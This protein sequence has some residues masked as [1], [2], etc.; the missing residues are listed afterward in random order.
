M[1]KGRKRKIVREFIPIILGSDENAYACARMFYE[2]SKEKSLVFCAKALPQTAHSGILSRFVIEDFDSPLV[3]R[4]VMNNVLSRLQLKAK[5]LLIIPCSDY[6]A[7]LVIR[8]RAL[9]SKYASSPIIRPELYEKI[10]DKISFCELCE[11]YGISH[12]KTE[13]ALPYTILAQ[14]K[15]RQFP[16]VLKPAN[17]N[18][19]EYLHSEFNGKKKVYICTNES[20]L[21]SA[22]KGFIKTGYNKPVV[23]QEYIR[24]GESL[25]RVVNAY[26]DTQGRV[27]L[28]GA[29]IPLLEYKNDREIGN[30]AAIRTVFD[31]KLC[32]EA[33]DILE[34]LGYVGFANFDVKIDKKTGRYV[35]LELNPRQ[36]RSSYYM[37]V[38]GANLMRALYDDAVL[39]KEY[40]GRRYAEN[41]GIWINE[42]VRVIRREMNLRGLSGDERVISG[43]TALDVTYDFSIPRAL[44]LM[45]RRLGAFIKEI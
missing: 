24:G 26:C 1:K 37:H 19:F 30:Y 10:C 32:D 25:S 36:G 7:E 45:R 18:S 3:F 31:R 38:A 4:S 14:N 29:G 16:L 34:R 44:T 21:A 42:P 9:I 39:G 28:I 27:R 11:S 15:T 23:L 8:N 6:Y 2:I 22:L 12:P 40:D 20:E 5:K 35:F 13:I 43:K 41:D 17:S 33:A